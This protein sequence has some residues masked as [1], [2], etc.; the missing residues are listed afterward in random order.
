MGKGSR[1]FTVLLGNLCYIYVEFVN[2]RV[3]GH[4]TNS[5][6]SIYVL[7]RRDSARLLVNIQVHIDAATSAGIKRTSLSA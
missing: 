7:R 6:S 1:S 2:C 5:R 3:N 4:T